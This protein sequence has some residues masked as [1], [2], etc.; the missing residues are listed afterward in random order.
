MGLCN[1]IFGFQ[2]TPV[3]E[4]KEEEENIMH[5]KEVKYKSCEVKS[6]DHIVRGNNMDGKFYVHIGPSYKFGSLSNAISITRVE[7][8]EALIDC[9]VDLKG[10][11]TG[12]ISNE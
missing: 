12:G 9:L 4:E 8:C 11:L 1:Y 3:K 7:E 2:S 5:C 6:L 10:A